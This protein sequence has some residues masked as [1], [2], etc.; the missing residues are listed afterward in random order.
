MDEKIESSPRRAEGGIEARECVGH[1]V[2]CD[3]EVALELESSQVFFHWP[4]DQ[5][6]KDLSKLGTDELVSCLINGKRFFKP[7]GRQ[8]VPYLPD[9]SSQGLVGLPILLGKKF[10]KL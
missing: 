9:L 8:I 4:G 1:R 7:G 3:E 5:I 6:T 2:H 10:E